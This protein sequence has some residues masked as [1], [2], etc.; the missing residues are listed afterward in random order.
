[1]HCSKGTYVRSLVHDI[2]Q[3]MGCGATVSSLH[4]TQ[5]AHFNVMHAHA[6]EDLLQLD[7]DQL[8]DKTIKIQSCLPHH[9]RI[10]LN[11]EQAIR[12]FHGKAIHMVSEDNCVYFILTILLAIGSIK[13]NN[14]YDKRLPCLGLE[15]NI[16]KYQNIS[17]T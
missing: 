17:C 13:N 16:H 6:L 15:I 4:R 14:V 10:E 5:L 7:L 12:L 3:V 9:F 8:K 11:L 2:G 1:M